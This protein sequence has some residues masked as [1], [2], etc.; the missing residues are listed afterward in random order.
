MHLTLCR[1]LVIFFKTN[2]RMHLT[3]SQFFSE[4]QYQ[5]H[6]AHAPHSFA[7]LQSC[8][9]KVQVPSRFFGQYCKYLFLDGSSLW[10]CHQLLSSQGSAQCLH[11]SMRLGLEPRATVSGVCKVPHEL[12]HAA[13]EI[14]SPYI[15]Q[16]VDSALKSYV[17]IQ[18]NV[19]LRILSRS[20]T[21]H[22][23]Q[24]SSHGR[25]FCM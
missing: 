1:S 12:C 9:M 19:N 8:K 6:H 21:G 10:D 5:L 15:C 11:M 23:M 13:C 20:F 14:T 17:E 24:M 25:R 2:T 22:L 3:L 16:A 18:T 7:V 4:Y